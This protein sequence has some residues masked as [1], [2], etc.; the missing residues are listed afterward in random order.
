[1]ARASFL[2]LLVVVRTESIDKN[3][4]QKHCCEKPNL[5]DYQ[6]KDCLLQ[7]I[8]DDP[9]Y[10]SYNLSTIFS[11]PTELMMNYHHLMKENY[12]NDNKYLIFDSWI[13]LPPLLSCS[14]Q[15]EC[16]QDIFLLLFKPST[17]IL[18]MSSLLSSSDPSDRW[19]LILS[20]DLILFRLNNWTLRLLEDWKQSSNASGDLSPHY[21]SFIS[22]T[23]SHCQD[24]PS[25]ELCL[26]RV[27]SLPSTVL[28]N[29]SQI[30]IVSVDDKN[31]P[32]SRLF[33][34]G[35]ISPTITPIE[36][37]LTLPLVWRSMCENDPNKFSIVSAFTPK[38]SPTNRTTPAFIEQGLIQ[39]LEI[40][41]TR[42]GQSKQVRPLLVIN[43]ASVRTGPNSET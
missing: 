7:Y 13:D 6:L 39:I 19:N 34:L 9:I 29:N 36:R 40:C 25:S 38:E 27:L 17:I 26:D 2:F 35:K 10:N 16:R 31:D 20:A 24:S 1:M 42:L 18:Q 22:F 15:G 21:D 30:L 8:Y 14:P 33:L 3:W 41:K 37:S 4:N 32:S 5:D 28:V 11:A 12:W 23:K 43:C